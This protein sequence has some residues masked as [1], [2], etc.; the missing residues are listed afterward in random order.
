MSLH[1]H[2]PLL[3]VL[4]LPLSIWAATAHAAAPAQADPLHA[5]M[6][7]D[8]P[9]Q[10]EQWVGQRLAAEQASLAKL[11]AVK[12]PRTVANTLQPFD[13]AQNQL[14]LAGNEAYLLFAVGKTAPLRDK[15]QELNQKIASVATDLSLNRAVYDAIAAVPLPAGD[16]ASRQYLQRTLLEYR[17]A[18]V[19][20]DQ[21]KRAAIHALQDKITE[22]S[23]AFN[24]NVQN[25]KQT[26][27]ATREELDG[28]PDDYIARHQPGADGRYTLSTDEP[29]YQPV[30]TFARNAG[31]R[32]RIYLAYNTR[33]YPAN[34]QVLLD[35]LA[36]PKTWTRPRPG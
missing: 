21:A 35:I 3:P 18:G 16:A 30:S 2:R 28:L 6:G 31:L 19:N 36:A 1:R 15:A 26:V 29:D 13:E 17:L 22:L 34:K 10:L 20:Q 23:L 12:G 9:A 24:H 4:L 33:A 27:T 32:H 5:W 25:G 11:L 14:A 8:D 7:G